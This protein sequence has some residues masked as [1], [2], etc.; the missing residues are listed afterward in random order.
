MFYLSEGSAGLNRL[1]ISLILSGRADDNADYNDQFSMLLDEAKFKFSE[2][3]L[4]QENS[5]KK[6]VQLVQRK[7]V[8]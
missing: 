7:L 5:Q 4:N 8:K 6:L 2:Y 1:K 3:P